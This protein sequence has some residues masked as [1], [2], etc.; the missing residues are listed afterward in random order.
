MAKK[1]ARI[2]LGKNFVK[3][4]VSKKLE[5]PLKWVSVKDI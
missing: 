4:I 2:A 3:D 1:S 5:T